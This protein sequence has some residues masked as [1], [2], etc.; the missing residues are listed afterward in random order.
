MEWQWKWRSDDDSKWIDYDPNSNQALNAAF[1]SNQSKCIVN[2][3]CTY[4]ITFGDMLQE[5]VSSHRKRKVLGP[6]ITI[7]D[8]SPT[9]NVPKQAQA[10]RFR[11]EDYASQ[12]SNKIISESKRTQQ[13][14]RNTTDNNTS[15]ISE[16]ETSLS[17]LLDDNLGF[18]DSQTIYT[19]QQKI[20]TPKET[21]KVTEKP[22]EIRRTI[23][24]TMEKQSQASME[25]EAK[26]INGNVGHK[27]SPTTTEP[28]EEEIE[29]VE[30]F[31]EP[32]LDDLL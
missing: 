20:E 1:R 8:S 15:I 13:Q 5:N 18:V 10:E 26:A 21:K 19:P 16:E 3:S 7:I 2:P 27:S 17:E 23:G 25:K 22:L 11:I 24:M 14:R 30:E 29:V 4:Q 6:N 9:R 31:Q 12:L 32:S 28:K